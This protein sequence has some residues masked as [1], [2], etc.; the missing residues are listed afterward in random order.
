[1]KL[2]KAVIKPHKL[3]AVHAA[4]AK[5]GVAGLTAGEVK[6]FDPQMSHAEIHRGRQYAVAFMPMV[7]VEAM[8]GDELAEQTVEIIRETAGT[9]SPGDGAIFV[10]EML[11]AMRIHSGAID[12]NA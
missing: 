7:E 5:I 10:C 4:L 2:I 6:A 11:S 1:M 9:G 3:D 8:V 12:E